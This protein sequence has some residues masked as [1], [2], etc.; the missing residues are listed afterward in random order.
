MA[1][2]PNSIGWRFFT[3]GRDLRLTLLTRAD[4]ARGIWK[5]TATC[6]TEHRE[7]SSA[8]TFRVANGS[9]HGLLAAHGDMRVALFGPLHTPRLA[10]G[11]VGGKLLAKR[12]IHSKVGG[13]V[14]ALHAT[15]RLVVPPNVMRR[16]GWVTISHLSGGRYDIHIW[17]PWKGRVQV[18]IPRSPH[19]QRRLD[20]VV[21]LD[22]GNWTIESS[23]FGQRTVSVDQL[24]IFSPIGNLIGKARWVQC[25]AGLAGLAL[26]GADV[27][28]AEVVLVC[29]KA[30]GVTVLRYELSKPLLRLLRLPPCTAYSY[31]SLLTRACVVEAPTVNPPS[32]PSP[33][34]PAP[35][36]VPAPAPAPAPAPS[37]PTPPSPSPP[38]QAWLFHIQDVFYLGTWIR[39]DPND[40]TWY[41][42]SNEPVDA[43]YWASNGT[44]VAVTCVAAAAPYRVKFLDGHYETW[45]IW[46]QLSD[47]NWFPSAA[48]QETNSNTNP[49]LPIC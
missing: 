8:V 3:Q 28:A 41:T 24:S 43:A 13:S 30:I 46:F 38:P 4:A 10:L 31:F 14:V 27:A 35:A 42:G 11:K 25:A 40:G 1:P 5:L 49:G 44:A 2:V 17:A 23:T 20:A 32:E 18:T 34:T 26:P 12:F 21:H 36:P 7:Q 29:F 19:L 45:N 16:P 39:R 9:G 6:R 15:V 22:N 33:P 37:P 47:G 48:A